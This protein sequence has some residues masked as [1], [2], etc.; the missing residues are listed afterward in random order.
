MTTR[1]PQ[2]GWSTNRSGAAALP[3]GTIA[4]RL[5]SVVDI[6]L[7]T[8]ICVA[9]FVFGGRHDLGRLVFVAAVGITS[10]AWFVRQALLPKAAWT[11]SAAFAFVLAAIALMLLQLAP[12][13]TD[14]LARLSPRTL[15][16]LP[17]WTGGDA[18]FQLGTWQTIS[19]TPHET[20]LALAML[21][22][23]ALLIAVLSQRIQTTG[24]V[25]KLLN[26]VGISA[27]LM[28]AFGILQFLFSNGQFFW[29]YL[30]PYRSTDR[31]AMGAFMNRNHFASFLVLGVAPLARWLVSALLAQ[32]IGTRRKRATID[33]TAL[34]LPGLLI[35]A[36]II[37]LLA[38]AL[39]FSKGG[40]LA[41][42]TAVVVMSALCWH[43]RL[44][45]AKYFYGVAGIGVVLVGLLSIY[46]Y[47][48]LTDRLDD[49]TVGSVDALDEGMGRRKV[50]AANL[51]AIEHGWL[52]GSGAGS[53][54]EISPVYLKDPSTKEYT[55]AENGYLQV[56][57]EM[58]VGGV[59]LLAAAILLCGGWC[60]AC[61][62]R[63]KD[64]AQRLCFAAAAAGVA[65]SLVHSVVDFVW[66]IPACMSITLALGVV[67]LRLS[68][69]SLPKERRTTSV[70][71]LSRP[72]WI[73][74]AAVSMLLALWSSYVFIGP[75][76]AAIHWDRYTRNAVA[77]A[78][79][80]ENQNS[81]LAPPLNSSTASMR[82]PLAESMLYHLNQTV[83]WDPAFARAH[84]RLA[85]R[86]VERFESSLRNSD[87]V[88]TLQQIREAA[89][90]SSFASRDELR[91]WLV[92]AFGVDSEL[93]FKA[94]AHARQAAAQSPLQGDAY[95]YL[96][97][98]SF[99]A[100]EGIPSGDS[101]KASAAL[102]AQGAKV[103]P[104]D[105]D[106]I[107]QL[108][109][110]P[111]LQGDLESALVTWSH[112]FGNT[113]KHQQLIVSQLAGR[114]P[115]STFIER[116]QPD[117]R[118]L[119]EIWAQYRRLGQPEDLQQLVAYTEQV[120]RRDAVR[121]GPIPPA[122]LWLWQSAVF[123]D[124][125]Q[126]DL[127]LACLEEAYKRDQHVF[128]VRFL[129]GYSLKTAGRLSEAE[130]HL[131]WC[132]AR[133]PENKSLRSAINELARLRAAQRDPDN[134]T[135]DAPVAWQQ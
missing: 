123:V 82:D 125:Q 17:L 60:V 67:I 61:V 128:R 135:A 63:L 33:S 34:V 62:G 65:A 104:F 28:A 16:L 52:T 8:I 50:W 3:G 99:L 105:G 126:P 39:S 4:A 30:H 90:S 7:L 49:F 87:N 80:F 112:C 107:Y 68:Q 42:A 84:L 121:P 77:S 130:P 108:G 41:L 118:T 48:R 114:I 44:V 54:R 111:L 57:T 47:D 93:L 132:L 35:A 119:R 117:W 110:L 94:Y 74:C 106:V 27:L 13:P 103:S 91:N 1:T 37:V 116:L 101:A 72:R 120:T 46:G 76:V 12:L 131:R 58:G 24:D 70:R 45:D 96:A 59:A 31:C 113:G 115:A 98:L 38:I 89:Q 97:E 21:V 11:R 15:E 20:K 25:E 92:R 95:V 66:Y 53:H 6:G 2:H 100:N 19:F 75:A 88:M 127:A 32:G 71:I 129:L 134:Y 69:L 5:L 9:P 51:A 109:M 79:Y 23:Y 81:P 102:V 64:P 55:H 73:E 10:C 29:C 83:A 133:N 124:T 56:A 43:W 86:Y 40:I 36:L 26:A 85:V 14:W 18:S 78:R 122:Y 22:S